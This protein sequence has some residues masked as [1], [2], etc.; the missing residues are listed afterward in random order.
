VIVTLVALNP[1]CAVKLE[2]TEKSSSTPPYVD[3]RDAALGT[4][5][6][7]EPSQPINCTSPAITC[8][9]SDAFYQLQLCN[10]VSKKSTE[11][12]Y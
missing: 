1:L 8:A 9:S 6:E 7:F 3:D 11:C 12:S 10:F 5:R 4:T 2:E